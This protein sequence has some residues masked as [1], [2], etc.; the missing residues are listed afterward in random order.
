VNVVLY[1][2][3]EHLITQTAPLYIS[4]ASA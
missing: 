1:I 3:I 4:S 2:I